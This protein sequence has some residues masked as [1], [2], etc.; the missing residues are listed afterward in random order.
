MTYLTTPHD[1]LSALSTHGALASARQ[2]QAA[3]SSAARG[4]SRSLQGNLSELLQLMGVHGDEAARHGDLPLAVRRVRN[5]DT[6]Y[7]EGSPAESLYF[8]RGGAFKV[9]HTDEEGYQHVLSFAGRGDVLGFDAYGEEHHPSAAS[10]LEES[11][12]FVVLRRELQ[13]LCQTVPALSRAMHLAAGRALRHGDELTDVMAAVAAEVRLARFLLQLSRRMEAAGQSPRR[14]Y[15]RMCRRD[16][17]SNLGVAAETISRSFAVLASWG[18]V[19]VDD[20]EVEILDMD[21]LRGVARSTRR[22]ADEG[23]HVRLRR[24]PSLRSVRA[25]AALRAGAL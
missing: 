18:L 21:G 6:L 23:G 4:A 15:L 22:Q 3:V 17:A 11:S 19:N 10:A 9:F 25:A 5:R 12:V 2:A 13:T 20:R 14:F 1:A 16:L 8:V 24:P 7:H